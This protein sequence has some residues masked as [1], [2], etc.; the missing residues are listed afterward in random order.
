MS[1]RGQAPFDVVTGALG[2]TGRH[3]VQRLIARGRAVLGLTNHPDRP[4]ALGDRLRTAPLTFDRP[5]A[6]AERLAGA[7]VLYNTYWIRFEHGG[8]TFARAIENTKV[9]LRAAAAVGVRRVVHVSIT[10]PQRGAALG[11]PYFRGKAEL[12]DFLAGLPL[13]RAMLR[14]AVIFGGAPGADILVNNIAWLL[15]RSPV[16]AVPGRGE[17]RVQPIHV[18]DL[19]EL[20]VRSAANSVDELWEAVGPDVYTFDELV[21]A[22]AGAVH[23]RARLLHVPP[24]LAL[25]AARAFGRAL[26]DVLLTRDE[27][28]GLMA[29][30]LVSPA[31]G[32]AAAP[33]GTTRFSAWLA[34]AAP[35]LGQSYASELARHFR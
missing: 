3:I 15:R 31:V 4:H 2:Y 25:A 23:S 18:D 29:D 32:N 14:P 11:L 28:R 12:E 10:Q 34:D 20:A 7:E 26:G 9:L 17:Y 8:R 1:A 6:L 19:A 35:Q 27:L 24:L 5:Q 21:R 13:S 22:I 33:A 30:L 16:F